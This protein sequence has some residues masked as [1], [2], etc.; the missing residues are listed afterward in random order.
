[1]TLSLRGWPDHPFCWYNNNRDDKFTE[2]PKYLPLAYMLAS[3]KYVSHCSSSFPSNS[4][5][6][7]K[8]FRISVS[9][10]LPV[11]RE[12][13]RTSDFDSCENGQ[14]KK[15]KTFFSNA[16]THC[17]RKQIRTVPYQSHVFPIEFFKNARKHYLQAALTVRH[18]R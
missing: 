18:P 5:M 13:A 2:L 3:F 8:N 11:K 7:L 4:R 9:K 6:K 12:N 10:F 16:L 1:M 14:T 17:Q 15:K